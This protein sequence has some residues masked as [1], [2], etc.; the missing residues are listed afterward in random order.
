M[1]FRRFTPQIDATLNATTAPWPISA[2]ID[3]TY[4]FI[5]FCADLNPD[6]SSPNTKTENF[7]EGDYICLD[8]RYAAGEIAY[9][10]VKD[11]SGGSSTLDLTGKF[12]NFIFI[13]LGSISL[14]FGW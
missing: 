9:F 8:G 3:L 10:G 4:L 2:E 7:A 13:R 14:I 6:S 1:V 11:G 5:S 12:N